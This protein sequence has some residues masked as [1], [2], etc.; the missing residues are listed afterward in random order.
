MR[1]SRKGWQEIAD[2]LEKQHGLK[3]THRT[4]FRFFAR[5]TDPKRKRPLGFEEAHPATPAA[6][7]LSTDQTPAARAAA[8]SASQKARE[9]ARRI[10][11]DFQRKLSEPL[12]KPYRP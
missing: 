2:H 4:L 5:A 10:Q 11:H 8:P 1:R 7:E 12:I 9:Q 3:V 6:P